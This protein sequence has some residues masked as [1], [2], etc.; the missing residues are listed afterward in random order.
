M[1]DSQPTRME[2]FATATTDH[3]FC[4]FDHSDPE[5]DGFDFHQVENSI[6]YC[7]QLF[8]GILKRKMGSFRIWVLYRIFPFQP[9]I[10][11]L[12]LGQR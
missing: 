11:I 5:P 1:P 4:Q 9:S 3:R 6:S 8:D 2:V 12:G 10:G 7:F